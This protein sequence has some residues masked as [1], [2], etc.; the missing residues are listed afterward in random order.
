MKFLYNV[1]IAWLRG[2]LIMPTVTHCVTIGYGVKRPEI[3]RFILVYWLKRPT[4]PSL[5]PATPQMHFLPLGRAIHHPR[6]RLLHIS[7]CHRA[8]P[9]NIGRKHRAKRTHLI[10]AY[11]L[12]R[13]R[14]HLHVHHIRPRCTS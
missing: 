5:V 6:H 9:S 13:V 10:L 4:T 14:K 11:Q 1:H 12:N 7:T 8:D 2:V 3:Y